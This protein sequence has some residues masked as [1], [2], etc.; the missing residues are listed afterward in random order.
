MNRAVVQQRASKPRIGL[1][2]PIIVTP[3]IRSRRT[4]YA[5]TLRR[6][7]VPTNSCLTL[8]VLVALSIAVPAQD[9]VDLAVVDRIKREAF[10]RSEVM[11]HLFHLTDVHLRR[12]AGWQR[13]LMIREQAGTQAAA[14]FNMIVVLDW[15]E[16][17]NT[18]V[19]AGR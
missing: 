6:P 14:P 8:A 10:E 5:S 13:F 12:L 16:E 7:D 11:D 17:L 18:R 3:L 4:V 19:P 1:T 9:A 15:G 2:R